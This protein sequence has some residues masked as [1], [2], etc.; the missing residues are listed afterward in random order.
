MNRK[1]HLLLDCLALSPLF[2]PLLDLKLG[3]FRLDLRLELIRG[4][5]K[6][7]KRLTHLPRDAGQLLRSKKQERQNEQN[8]SIGKTHSPI[9]AGR[10]RYWLLPTVAYVFGQEIP[11]PVPI[12]TSAERMLTLSSLKFFMRSWM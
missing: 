1:L 2:F 11:E 8:G 9:I 12:L 6:F 5:L 3:D 7:G 4:A 10:G